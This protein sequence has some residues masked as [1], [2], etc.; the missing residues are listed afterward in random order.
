MKKIIINENQKGFLF[1]NGK[2]VKML[3]AGKYHTYGDKCIEVVD[4]NAPLHSDY[5]DIDTL[6]KNEEL[7]RNV[8]VVEVTDQQL[9][10]HFI[11]G[12][13]DYILRAGKH[14]FWNTGKQHTFQLVDIS[15]PTVAAEVPEYIFNKVP[16]SYFT[17]VEISEY[18]RGRL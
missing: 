10:L 9:A 16:N 6:I 14:A 15:T 8:S 7:A 4:M 18:E 1:H 2:F 12:K 5:C 11:E 3:D 13:F 17:K